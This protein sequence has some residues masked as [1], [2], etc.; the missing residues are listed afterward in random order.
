VSADYVFEQ[1]ALSDIPA[2]R[3]R[4]PAS[5]SALVIAAASVAG[6]AADGPPVTRE[7]QRGVS[8]GLISRDGH[9]VLHTVAATGTCFISVAARSAAAPLKAIEVI[10][11]RLGRAARP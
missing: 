4:D 3:L 5:L 1:S 2:D 8:L 7:S 10:A 9:I 6:L 11:R